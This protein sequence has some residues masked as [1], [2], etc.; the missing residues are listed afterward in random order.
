MSSED[1]ALQP[2]TPIEDFQKKIAEAVAARLT[3]PSDAWRY[4]HSETVYLGDTDTSKV[5]DLIF[6]RR[7]EV[8]DAWQDLNSD[9]YYRRDKEA[10]KEALEQELKANREE[11]EAIADA[12]G[13][14]PDDLVAPWLED[15]DEGFEVSDILD[16]GL[17]TESYDYR[18]QRALYAELPFWLCLDSDKPELWQC[19]HALRIPPLAFLASALNHIENA[20][21]ADGG[22]VAPRNQDA[23]SV[24]GLEIPDADEPAQRAAAM[25]EAKFRENLLLVQGARA[26]DPGGSTEGAVIDAEHL[27]GLVVDGAYGSQTVVPAY[28]HMAAGSTMVDGLGLAAARHELLQDG[29]HLRAGSGYISTDSSPGE[30]DHTY[31]LKAPLDVAHQTFQVA[32]DSPYR[33]ADDALELPAHLKLMADLYEAAVVSRE[34]DRMKD[35]FDPTA[36]DAAA[37]DTKALAILATAPRWAIEHVRGRQPWCQQYL[38]SYLASQGPVEQGTLDGELLRAIEQGVNIERPVASGDSAD[39]WSRVEALLA[40]GAR[41]DSPNAQGATAFQVASANLFPLDRI[42]Q[43]H[44]ATP[45][46]ET[47]GVRTDTFAMVLRALKL[48]GQ[49]SSE[50]TA[51]SFRA[52]IIWYLNEGIGP[53]ET[54][55]SGRRQGPF[56]D[57]LDLGFPDLVGPTMDA[58][59]EAHP[60]VDTGP[61]KQALL[62][63]AAMRLEPVL[64]SAMLA[65]GA[66]PDCVPRSLISG[67]Q[68]SIEAAIDGSALSAADQ[69]RQ[70]CCDVLLAFRR[71]R[72]AMAL[73]EDLADV[74]TCAP[75]LSF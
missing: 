68:Q 16:A 64:L 70:A 17:N 66:D 45:R 33:R 8:E 56:H 29:V 62:K 36:S 31:N 44:A 72:S 67:T 60:T 39:L 69:K 37:I 30:H 50:K 48:T 59:Q 21:E 61:I 75:A 53:D 38:T 3:A 34:G 1:L 28:L 7:F 47:S 24:W 26:I 15:D 65:R 5:H 35:P 41:A 4:D 13:E 49:P 20:S 55:A 14:D 74:T 73:I 54:C 71:R 12:L 42:A 57:L 51:E 27:I 2:K 43:L 22:L 23:L 25:Y 9:Y 19:L 52:R 46:T 10:V 6:G 32:S 18:G 58:L 40:L 11:L 63:E